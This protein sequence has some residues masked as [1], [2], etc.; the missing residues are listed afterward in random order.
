M[1]E[2]GILWHGGW[3]DA[4]IVGHFIYL[5]SGILWVGRCWDCWTLY[6]FEFR[7]FVGGWLVGL[8]EL[9]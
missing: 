2:F 6:I 9:T 1:L 4:G 5:N 3:V 7:D 8:L